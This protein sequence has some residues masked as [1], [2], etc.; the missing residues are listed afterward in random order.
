VH[1]SNFQSHFLSIGLRLFVLATTIALQAEIVHYH[2]NEILVG[3]EQA[4]FF[5]LY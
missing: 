2:I 3:G 1:I 5:T 4:F